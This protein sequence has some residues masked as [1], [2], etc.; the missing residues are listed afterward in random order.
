MPKR[1]CDC[2]PLNVCFVGE[3][4][5]NITSS[6]SWQKKKTKCSVILIHPVE[7]P[8]RF[9]PGPARK[10]TFISDTIQI[11]VSDFIPIKQPSASV[12]PYLTAHQS[13]T[14]APMFGHPFPLPASSAD[15]LT[16]P[17]PVGDWHRTAGSDTQRT[18]RWAELSGQTRHSTNQK[19]L[20]SNQLC[21]L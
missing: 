12:S 8:T 19:H 3:N 2:I 7:C 18:M 13:P 14:A 10:S 1:V 4:V 5:E 6:T 11:S 21:P 15:Q 9:Y 16:T 17:A 20:P